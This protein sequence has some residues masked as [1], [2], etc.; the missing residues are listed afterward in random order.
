MLGGID[1]FKGEARFFE[2]ACR[3]LA[4]RAG[5]RCKEI[6]FIGFYGICAVI[7]AASTF[8]ILIALFEFGILDVINLAV[9]EFLRLAVVPVLN[10]TV[11]TRDAAVNLGGLTANRALILFAGNIAVALAY[12][13]RRRKSVI[14][15]LVIFSDLL[16]QS[17]SGFPIG[18]F[19]AEECV[20]YGAG[21]I[22]RL[23]FILDVES[24]ENI[25]GVADGKAYRLF[26]LRR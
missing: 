8:G 21:G 10:G 17:G 4:V 18:E 3:D 1:L 6:C 19:F 2:H 5:G 25:L 22:E 15:K 7:A 12:G 13:I 20:E 11:V 16:Y 26:P 9:F 24:R 23:Q 14:R